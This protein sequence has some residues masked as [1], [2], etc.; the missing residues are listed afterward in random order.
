[1]NGS[2]SQSE[3]S[4]I[5]TTKLKLELKRNY[6]NLLKML[7]KF[8]KLPFILH[9]D[10]Y[11]FLKALVN[12]FLPTTYILILSFCAKVLCKIARCLSQCEYLKLFKELCCLLGD[13]F[14]RKMVK[15]TTGILD[16][17]YRNLN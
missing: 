13:L 14:Y 11:F 8:V 5:H 1:M 3:R 10:G 4:G 6:V 12:S 9:C 7:I 17:F 15:I 2:L 16:S